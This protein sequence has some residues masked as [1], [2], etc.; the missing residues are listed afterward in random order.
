MT[1]LFMVSEVIARLVDKRRGAPVAYAGLADDEASPLD[2]PDA[3]RRSRL[4]RGRGLTRCLGDPRR[5]GGRPVRPARLAGHVATSPGPRCTSVR[6]ASRIEGRL[7]RRG[8]G[9]RLRPAGRR[10]RLPRAAARRAPWRRQAHQSWTHGQVLLVEYD[11]RL[12][13]AVPGTAYSADGVLETVGRLAKAVGVRPGRFV[14]TPPPVT[15]RGN[16]SRWSVAATS[17]DRHPEHPGQPPRHRPALRARTGPD[18]GDAVHGAR[19]ARP[20]DR[21][22]R[23]PVDRARPRRLPAVPVAV[24]GLPARAGRDRAGLRQARRPVRPQAA[25]VLR[26][27]DVPARLGAVRGWPGA[28]RC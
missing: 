1:V 2:G 10:P 16:S 9:A 19:G 17:R 22:D 23:G 21:L 18:R 20:D 13:L 3:V 5:A 26:H 24:L 12:T 27:R 8:G 28:C 25:D 7:E 4:V 14:V 6:G 11:G 15:R